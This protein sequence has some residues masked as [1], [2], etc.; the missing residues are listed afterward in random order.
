M[1]LYPIMIDLEGCRVT[2]AEDGL[3]AFEL[4]Q[5]QDFDLVLMDVHMPTLDGLETTRRIRRELTGKKART[6]IIGL[7][8]SVMQDEQQH[9]LG[10]GMDAVIGKP[11]DTDT[12]KRIVNQ[13]ETPVRN[14]HTQP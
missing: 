9:Y 8:A 13:I 14:D 10:V 4:L 7:T 6:P 1:A 12:F 11:F 2:V 3:K 5:H